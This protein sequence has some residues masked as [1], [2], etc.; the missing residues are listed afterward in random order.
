M[1]TDAMS[2]R[3]P[4]VVPPPD[5]GLKRFG[6]HAP[7][8]LLLILVVFA[9][10]GRLL[11]TPFWNPLDLQILAEAA[12]LSRDPWSMLRH[13]GAYFS[14]PILQLVFVLEYRL[15]GLDPAGYQAVNL[16]VHAT[17]A[18]LVYM[19]VNMLFPRHRIAPLAALLFA[20][21]VGSYGKVLMG[22]A[23]LEPLLLAMMHILVLYFF[24]R[25]DFRHEG[26]TT[27][28]YYLLGLLLFVLA[29]F[30]RVSYVS[31][32]GAIVA[33]KALFYRQRAG[34]PVLDLG[35][36]LFAAVGAVFYIAQD[37][38]GFE[39]PSAL[40]AQAEPITYTWI[41]IKN[42][43]RYLVLMFF[44]LQ[45]S[46][47]LEDAPFWVSWLHTARSIIRVL[48]TLAIIS[49]SFFGFLFGNA[50]VRFFIAWTFI[51]VL[52]FSGMPESGHWLNLTHLYVTSLGFCVILAAGVRGTSELL[53]RAGWRRLLPYLVPLYFVLLSLGLTYKLDER[54]RLQAES[55]TMEQLWS[56]LQSEISDREAGTQ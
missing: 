44:P 7:V 47:L 46:S 54:N 24:I 43:F 4:E 10:F 49:Y 35:L 30:T 28:P 31:L 18:F 11:T 33:Y 8:Y 53:S 27:S 42:V 9:V 22:V 51:T 39:S 19:L 13:L 5:S 50:A 56:Q 38:W 3:A 52:P 41:S 55:P 34:R 48:I 16:F 12:Q 29:G 23:Q 36:L 6:V 17:N 1:K 20:L 14:Q 26:R 40:R 37:R 25:N 32:L 15:F 45:T 21:G 2:S